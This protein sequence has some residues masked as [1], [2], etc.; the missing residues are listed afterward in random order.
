MPTSL[1]YLNIVNF[2]KHKYGDEQKASPESSA[3]II[4]IITAINMLILEV[5]SQR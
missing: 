3:G 2:Q 5:R 1:R 4:I